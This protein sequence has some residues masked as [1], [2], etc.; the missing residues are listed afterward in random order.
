MVVPM[1]LAFLALKPY[2]GVVFAAAVV[3]AVVFVIGF[4]ALWKLE[5]TFH[6]DLDYVEV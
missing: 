6:K 5:E 3:G 1:T 4:V 2:G